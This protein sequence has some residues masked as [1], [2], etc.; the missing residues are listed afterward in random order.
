VDFDFEHIHACLVFGLGGGYGV[1][2]P[3]LMNPCDFRRN[4]DAPLQDPTSLFKIF[5]K[6][7]KLTIPTLTAPFCFF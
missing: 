6:A 7:E 1:V 4:F 3:S 2:D 5:G